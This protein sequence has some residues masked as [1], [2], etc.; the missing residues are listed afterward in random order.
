[1]IGSITNLTGSTGG[2]MNT[3]NGFD[4]IIKDAFNTSQ[5]NEIIDNIKET[6]IDSA[7]KANIGDFASNISNIANMIFDIY[8]VSNKIYVL[9]LF[10]F[11]C[12]MNWMVL[13]QLI[14]I[15]MIKL[16]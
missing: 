11:H 9:S 1:M 15:V 12:R 14:I 13:I 6:A 4:D 2:I 16:I 8:N 3:V 7:N 5:F 10:I